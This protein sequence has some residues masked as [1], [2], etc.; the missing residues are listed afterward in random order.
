M[1]KE[2]ENQMYQ[3]TF[4]SVLRKKEIKAKNKLPLEYAMHFLDNQCV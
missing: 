3:E 2:V 1:P 4:R